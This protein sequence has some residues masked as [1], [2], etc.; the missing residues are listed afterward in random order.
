MN[1]ELERLQDR[2]NEICQQIDPVAHPY[3]ILRVRQD[4]GS[5]HVE[6]DDN[7]FH[8]VVTE[9]GLDLE[10]RTT[11]DA[12]EILYWMIH[13]LTFWMGVAYEF[14]NRVE[15]PDARRAIFATWLELMKKAG[16]VMADRL[17]FDIAEIL[18]KNP[19]VC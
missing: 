8:Y 7:K 19:F 18:A 14:K 1:V 12:D 17:E 16:P 3:T 2:Y 15:G 6:F 5:A 11:P 9:R 10:R 4:N 13:D